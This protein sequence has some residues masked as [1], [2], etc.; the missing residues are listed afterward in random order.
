MFPLADQDFSNY[1]V[2]Q[3]FKA[4]DAWYSEMAKIMGEVLGR[5]SATHIEYQV[6]QQSHIGYFLYDAQPSAGDRPPLR[7]RSLRI[8]EQEF[9]VLLAV[10]KKL[11]N[12]T[13]VL[14]GLREE[15]SGSAG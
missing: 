12:L 11:E 5:L 10:Q 7:L 15:V 6:F 13:E 14:K 3:K 2:R 4:L 1:L 9:R 8:I